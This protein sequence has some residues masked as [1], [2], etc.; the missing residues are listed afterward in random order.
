MKNKNTMTV[1]IMFLLSLISVF[2]IW[3]TAGSRNKDSAAASEQYYYAARQEYVQEIRDYLAEKGYA[4]SGI[5]MNYVT[6]E[7]GTVE[8]TVTIHHRKIDKLDEEEKIHLAEECK[9][10]EAWVD[11]YIF[12]IVFL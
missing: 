7:D 1:I 11:P 10:L 2:G 3:G 8:Y 9:G 5:T 4:D 6:D 12:S